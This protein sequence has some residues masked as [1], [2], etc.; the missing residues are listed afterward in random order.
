[1][2]VSAGSAGLGNPN[3]LGGEV[4][5]IAGSTNGAN[6]QGGPVYFYGGGA[7]VDGGTAGG[8]NFIGGSVQGSTGTPGDINFLVGA[9]SSNTGVVGNFS[10]G[11]ALGEPVAVAPGTGTNHD[12]DLPVIVD[13]AQYYIRLYG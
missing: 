11:S 8:I 6:G 2:N 12:K 5:F 10:F 4:Y 13:G 9:F 3:G 1:M 7:G